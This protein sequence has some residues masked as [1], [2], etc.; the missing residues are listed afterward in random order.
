MTEAEIVKSEPVKL[1]VFRMDGTETG[2]LVEL[3]QRL[4]GIPRNDHVIYLAVKTEM[5]NR[6]QGT[7]ATK[8]RSLV[9]GGGRKPWRQKGRGAARVGTIRSPIWRG[10]GTAFGPQPQDFNMKL[11]RKARRLARRIAFSVKAETGAIVI[12]EDLKFDEP[13]TS[14]IAEMLKSFD[15]QGN[16][17][18][19]LLDENKPAVVKSCQ[20]IQ[21]I[22]VRECL[23]AS[24]VDILRARHLIICRSAIDILVGGLVDA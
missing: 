9:H 24:T 6:R 17:V 5:T 19:L 23:N 11:P 3:D 18:L 13:K 8:S 21:R 7:R 10:G 12:V 20:N 15:A 4:F 1:P 22:S 2:D 16:S 14:R